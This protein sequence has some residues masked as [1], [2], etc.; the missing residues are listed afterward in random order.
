VPS[1]VDVYESEITRQKYAAA[2]GALAFDGK[3]THELWVFHGTAPENV[4]RIMC[5][6][7]RIG[8]VDVGVTNGTALGLGVYAATG[9]DTPIHYSFDDAAER[10]AVILA[11]ALPG[12]VGAASHQGDSWRGGRDWWV[13]ADSAQLVPVYVV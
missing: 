12:E 5:G 3:D 11:R 1:Q 8:G 2:R 13:F 7:F 10:Q 4:P 9:P 6:G